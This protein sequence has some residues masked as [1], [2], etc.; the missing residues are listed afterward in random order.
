MTIAGTAGL[1]RM[2]LPSPVT[3][4]ARMP[5]SSAVMV[6]ARAP[7]P[8]VHN[9]S[10]VVRPAAPPSA[11]RPG[12]PPGP[13]AP[14]TLTRPPTVQTRPPT[15][16]PEGQRVSL[17]QREDV[18]EPELDQKTREQIALDALMSSQQQ[19]HPKRE[20]LQPR[21]QEVHRPASTPVSLS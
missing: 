5:T 8:V 16:V 13:R 12:A 15:Q 17:K 1:P 6:N 19:Q 18:K 14:T 10:T 3:S 20:F 2:T 11:V 7:A 9:L 4:L 21:E